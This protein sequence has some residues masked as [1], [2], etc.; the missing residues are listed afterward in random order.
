M[1]RYQASICA[2]DACR[3]HGCHSISQFLSLG[4][5]VYEACIY[6]GLKELAESFYTQNT[7]WTLIFATGF[8]QHLSF[9]VF[10]ANIIRLNV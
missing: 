2:D 7:F 10:A 3:L 8:M 9:L 6:M 1:S 5:L 4:A